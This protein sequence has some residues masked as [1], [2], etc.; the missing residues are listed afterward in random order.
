MILLIAGRG[1]HLE[2]IIR[3]K[4]KLQATGFEK[5]LLIT[6]YGVPK[7]L[8]NDFSEIIYVHEL[9][10]KFSKRKYILSIIPVLADHFRTNLAL[11]KNYKIS[12]MLSTGPGLAIPAS[13]ICRLKKIPIVYVESWSRFY[14]LSITGKFMNIISDL[15]IVQNKSLLKL[16]KK[17][18]YG[19]RL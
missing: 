19:G 5:F 1:G 10:N 13:I 2:Q 16:S 18:K 14:S 12:M 6:E 9:R 15:F 11:H 3:L 8:T 7:D 4:D 17:A